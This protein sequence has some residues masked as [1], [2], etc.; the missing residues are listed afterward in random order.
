MLNFVNYAQLV[1]D[2]MAWSE[3]LPRDIDLFVGIPRS[4][5]LVAN[6]LALHRN[7]ALSSLDEFAYARVLEGGF[8]DQ[9]RHI[10]KVFVVDDSS[11]SGRSLIRAE[12]RLKSQAKDYKILYGA[13]YVKKPSP[14]WNYYRLMDTPRVFEWNLFHGYW[15]QRACVDIDGVLCRDPTPEE[16]DDGL[17][18]SKFLHTVRPR[19]IPTVQIHSLVTNRL[20]RYRMD[21]RKWLQRHGVIF[22][23]LEM[24]SAS[25]KHARIKMGNHARIKAKYYVYSK[26][27]LF[28]ESSEK[29]AKEIARLSSKPVICTDTMVLYE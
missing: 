28:I 9:H 19:H 13:V 26:C 14:A 24:H 1:Q 15:I 3:E 21:T 25:T 17:R 7:V 11:L 29:Q 27:Q 4:G 6:L 18:Y 8:R 22:K 20:E 16:N 10:K 5:M 2:V 12:E 23:H